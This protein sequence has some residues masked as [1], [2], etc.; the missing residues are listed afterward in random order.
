MRLA[1]GRFL[2]RRGCT[3]GSLYCDSTIKLRI[4]KRDSIQW[5]LWRLEDKL[6]IYLRPKLQ[7][8]LARNSS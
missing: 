6:I 3:E 4:K 5:G 8:V 2:Q 7:S 1:H